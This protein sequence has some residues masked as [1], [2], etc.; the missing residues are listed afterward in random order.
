[1]K[2]IRLTTTDS[3]VLFESN[4]NDELVLRENPKIGLQNCSIETVSQTVAVDETNSTIT[5]VI[6]HRGTVLTRRRSLTSCT[7]FGTTTTVSPISKTASTPALILSE[8]GPPGPTE[9][10]GCSGSSGGSTNHVAIEAQRGPHTYGTSGV[11][12][13]SIVV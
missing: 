6:S 3:T 12:S 5:V 9:T 1:M 2:L 10:Y 7:L 11:T 13:G 4:F 8:P